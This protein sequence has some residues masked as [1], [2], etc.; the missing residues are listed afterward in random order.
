MGRPH[1]T[2]GATAFHFTH[3]VTVDTVAP[4]LTINTVA[5]DDVINAIEKGEALTVSGTSNG[6]EGST[7]TL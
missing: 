1:T 3:D 5:A 6:A 7:V 4:V 2:I